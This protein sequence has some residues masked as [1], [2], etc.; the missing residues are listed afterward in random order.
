MQLGQRK[1]ERAMNKS[2]VL[3][4][5]A[6]C[7]VPRGA[8]NAGSAVDAEGAK[9]EIGQGVICDT[10]QHVQRFVTL[11]G[12][13]EDPGAALEALNVEADDDAACQ[14]AFVLYTD[15][16]PIDQLEVG[17][18]L[19]KFIE[20]TVHAFGDGRTWIPVAPRVQYTVTVEK[21]QIA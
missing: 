10:V 20:I 15:D 1:M 3:F 19:F 8:A 5:A 12:G 4:L 9:G 17:R 18:R 11:R 21:G 6:L 2:I 13:G 16:K 7:L 14:F